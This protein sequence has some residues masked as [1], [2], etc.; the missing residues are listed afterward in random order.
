[1]SKLGKEINL[2]NRNTALAQFSTDELER[3]LLRRPDSALMTNIQNL[4]ARLQRALNET[5]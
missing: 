2:V 3:E 1:L 5:Q 4:T